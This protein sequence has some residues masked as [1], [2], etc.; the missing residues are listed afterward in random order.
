[1]KTITF[2]QYWPWDVLDQNIDLTPIDINIPHLAPQLAMLYGWDYVPK[3]SVEDIIASKYTTVHYEFEV[4]EQHLTY[5]LLQFPNTAY[6][7]F[8]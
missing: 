1:M 6:E 5:L 8:I 2:S 4:S 3:V 7:S